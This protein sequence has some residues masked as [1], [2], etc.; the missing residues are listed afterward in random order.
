M[1]EGQ[2]NLGV[3]KLASDGSWL[4]KVPANVPLALQAVDNFGMSLLPEPVWFSAR[5]NESRVC[6]GCHED[7][8]KTVVVDPGLTQAFAIGP[9]DAKGTVARAA[10]L[11]TEA[12][13]LNPNLITATGANA[14]KLVGMAW[15]KAIQ[16]I[17]NA[18]C[19]GCH[20]GT[21]G[22][23]NP[24]YTISTE[25]GLQSVSWTFDLRGIKKSLII[26]GEDLAGEWSASYFSVA[27]PDME[28]FEENNLVVSGGFKVYMKPQDARGSLLV[29]KVNP[30][31]LYPQPSNERAF[32]TSPHSQTAPGGYAELTSTEFL[33]LILAADMGVNYYARENSPGATRY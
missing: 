1:F 3:A 5:A 20:E 15:D 4:A 22:A 19:I 33:K 30:T 14:D 29:Q 28:A 13:L 7:R 17:F 11:S 21:P 18:K 27:G 8:V 6:G 23:N 16:P 9:L 25:D 26:D 12:D 31:R 24:T 10:R 2:A 32:T